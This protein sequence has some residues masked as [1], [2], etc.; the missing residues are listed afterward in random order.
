MYR[1][2]T[3]SLAG[4]VIDPASFLFFVATFACQRGQLAGDKRVCSNSIEQFQST[5]V[6]T[7]RRDERFAVRWRSEMTGNKIRVLTA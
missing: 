7:V 4:L 2:A 1:Q 6:C 5:S 3:I